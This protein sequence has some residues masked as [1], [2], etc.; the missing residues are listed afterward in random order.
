[1]VLELGRDKKPHVSVFTLNNG[2]GDNPESL[3]TVCFLPSH[4]WLNHQ[5]HPFGW[6]KAT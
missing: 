5:L 1:M 3:T 6:E 4:T 2:F